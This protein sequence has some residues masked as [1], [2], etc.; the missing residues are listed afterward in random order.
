MPNLF[1]EVAGEIEGLSTA[2]EVLEAYERDRP[3]LVTFDTESP[4]FAWQRP[5]NEPFAI[6][7]SWGFEETFYLHTHTDGQPIRAVAEVMWAIWTETPTI[8]GH[9]TWYDVHVMNRYWNH[10]PGDFPLFQRELEDTM[11]MD[12]CL[13]EQRHHGLKE[14]C[15]HFDIRYGAGNADALRDEIKAWIESETKVSGVEPSYQDVPAHLMV[16]YARQDAYLTLKLYDH[17]KDEMASQLAGARTDRRDIADIYRLEKD[18]AWVLWGAEERGMRLD[19]DFC[20]KQLAELRP[21][22]DY[23]K[24]EMS[25]ELGWEMNP[26]SSEDIAKALGQYGI[27]D[28][29]WTNPTTG[30]VNLP[31]WRLE[32]IESD[33]NASP[34]VMKVLEY[35]ETAK[36]VD[37]YFDNFVTEKHIDSTGQAIIKCNFK[38]CGARTG[39]MSVVHPA[40][41]TLPKKIGNVRGAFIAREGHQLIF[42]DWAGQEIRILGHFLDKLHDPTLKDMFERDL[43]ADPHTETAAM[44]FGVASE[45][46]TKDQRGSAKAI[47]FG[48]IYGMGQAKLAKTLGLELDEAKR[49]LY[50][51]YDTIPG[52]RKLKKSTETA[53]KSRGYVI[54]PFGRRHREKNGKFAYRAINSLCQGTGADACKAA[55]IATD[56]A[57]I[58]GGFKSRFVM[59]VHDELIIEAPNDEVEA[60]KPII[61]KAMTDFADLLCVPLATD[62]NVADRWSDAK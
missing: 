56:R 35:R 50:R 19:L 44:L 11:L 54:T 61:D 6:T 40:L 55:I 27:T 58:H 24:E 49:L 29:T 53:M 37:S 48:I 36:V 32:E 2:A 28:V 30:K 12:A 13:D 42:A 10:W 8:V 57:L 46:V 5:E 45:E 21:Q 31:K 62:I 33:P 43:M 9:N 23:L 18:L 14:L 4:H 39:R 16:P 60:V 15:A 52:I 26:G 22:I 34:I 17:L 3:D 38:Q 7:L 51:Y 20:N 25:R 59:A 41:Q 1:D 47:N